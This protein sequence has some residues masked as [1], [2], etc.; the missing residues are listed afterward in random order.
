[1]NDR[2]FRFIDLFA[3]A[4]GL[5]EGFIMN[6]NFIPL[7]HV[8]MNKDA[9]N[10][11]RTRSS[12]YYLKE[13][14]N[15]SIYEDYQKGKITRDEL[16]SNVPEGLIKTIINNEISETS[17]NSIFD[18]ID[19]VIF[20]EKIE[21][22]DLIIGGPPC[23]AYSLV[24]RAV[25]SDKM[26][27]DPRNFLYKQ[28][29]SFLQHYH[30]KMFIFENVPGILTAKK[31]ETFK[32]I[33]EE[34]ERIGYSADF[35]ILNA[36]DFGV[37]QNRRRV[38]IIGWKKEYHL[39]YPQ[40]DD[41][42]I[43]INATVFDILS[44][45]APLERGEEKNVY[46]KGL[47]KYLKI[48]GIRGKQ[49]VL[50]QHVCRKHN[51]NDVEIYRRV[52]K[53]WNKNH[54]RLKYTDLPENLRTHKNTTAF[55]DRYKVLAGDIR[56]SH[57]MI[58]HIAKDGHYFIHPD[59]KQCRSISVREAARIQSFPDNYFFEGSRAAK[60]V[61]IGN[62]VPPLMAKGLATKIMCILEEL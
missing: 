8:E 59:I 58:A 38:I 41:C 18:E 13:K 50:T 32:T 25:S 14:N 30:P 28:Y 40:F 24:G 43:N 54:T 15:I 47:N 36:A 52:I 61:Q 3:G 21:E 39:E 60:Y 12:Y 33:L 35:K 44:D 4:G 10:T 46:I 29:I 5:S 48:S 16:Y 6:G 23:Q 45:L 42:N 53:A 57:T 9:C 11:L 17:I 55:L 2:K 20:E 62:A 51:E 1:M 26:I 31:G 19:N 27:T 37:L 7:A 56:C 22:L 49:D 34:F